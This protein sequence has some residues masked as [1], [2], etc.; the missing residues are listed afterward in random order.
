MKGTTLALFGVATHHRLIRWRDTHN[1][2]V[3]LKS[4]GVMLIRGV[5]TCTLVTW[6]VMLLYNT[7][8]YSMYMSKNAG[9]APAQDTENVAVSWIYTRCN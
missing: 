5:V 7:F 9:E 3:I 4:R 6:P 1:M 8:V 2:V